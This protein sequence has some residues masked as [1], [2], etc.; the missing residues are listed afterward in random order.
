MCMGVVLDIW[1]STTRPTVVAEDAR[2]DG[3]L[4]VCESR[5]EGA[6]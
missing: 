1:A 2:E 5:G 6:V 3:G 4:G